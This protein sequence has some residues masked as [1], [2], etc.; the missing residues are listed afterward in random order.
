MKSFLDEKIIIWNK[1]STVRIAFFFLQIKYGLD[2]QLP[3]FS[4]A[5]LHLPGNNQS[6]IDWELQLNEFESR[7]Q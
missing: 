5:P 2:L 4:V 3:I 6:D 1:W 7:T